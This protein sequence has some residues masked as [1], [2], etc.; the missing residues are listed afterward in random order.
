MPFRVAA[1]CRATSS[2]CRPQ[3]ISDFGGSFIAFML[4][5]LFVIACFFPFADVLCRLK[6]M[7]RYESGKF[8]FDTKK[9]AFLW[10]AV[11]DSSKA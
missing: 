3:E 9:N 6:R 8:L 5:W 4:F 11:T 10:Y 7:K 1:I 2:H